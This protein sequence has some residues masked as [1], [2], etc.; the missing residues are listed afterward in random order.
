MTHRAQP[1]APKEAVTAKGG[2]GAEVGPECADTLHRERSPA[3]F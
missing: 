1:T 2:F 3:P